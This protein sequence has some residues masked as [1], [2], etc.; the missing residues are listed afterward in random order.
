M[1]DQDEDDAT[2]QRLL[3]EERERTEELLASAQAQVTALVEQA[4]AE[5]PEPRIFIEIE[6]PEDDD[7]E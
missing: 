1:M 2:V 4:L 3:A 6:P 5:T 7:D